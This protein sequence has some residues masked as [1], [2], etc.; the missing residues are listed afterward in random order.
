MQTEDVYIYKNTFAICSDR[1][2]KSFLTVGHFQFT[3]WHIKAKMGQKSISGKG[4]IY[5]RSI[6][7]LHDFYG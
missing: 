7:M 2:E 6:D 5:D 3:S 1:V 4:K